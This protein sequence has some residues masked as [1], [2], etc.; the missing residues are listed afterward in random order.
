[1]G[2]VD[3]AITKLEEQLGSQ[4]AKWKG[5]VLTT[6]CAAYLVKG[7]LAAASTTCEEAVG[8]GH[9][10]AY[11]NRGVLRAVQG[12][13]EGA[14]HDFAHASRTPAISIERHITAQRRQT[15]RHNANEARRRL[16]ARQQRGEV[17][18]AE[19]DE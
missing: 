16:A 7:D 12:N 3:A 19:G 4:N 13:F 8:E 11:N 17:T 18:V 15:A 5:S 10:E 14:D 6:L 9:R 2:Q 1:M